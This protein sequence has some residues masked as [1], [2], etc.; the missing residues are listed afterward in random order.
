[1]KKWFLVFVVAMALVVLSACKRDEY[2]A[3]FV[4]REPVTFRVQNEDGQLLKG[5]SIRAEER[6]GFDNDLI[7]NGTRYAYTDDEGMATIPDAA[8]DNHAAL[9]G[10]T[11]GFTFTATGYA[12]FDTVFNTWEGIVDIVLFR[13]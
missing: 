1:M 9:F 3:V 5:V 6:D 7:M 8:C 12:V 13:D 11:N 4:N 2:G 10:R